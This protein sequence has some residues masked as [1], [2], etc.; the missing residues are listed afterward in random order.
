LTP[1]QKNKHLRRLWCSEISGPEKHTIFAGKAQTTI[2]ATPNRS[3]ISTRINISL[4]RSIYFKCN[5]AIESLPVAWCQIRQLGLVSGYR[6]SAAHILPT[7]FAQ[8]VFELHLV[9]F[10]WPG[11]PGQRWTVACGGWSDRGIQKSQSEYITA[12][13][14]V[15]GDQI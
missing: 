10:A 14:E 5:N 11:R 15:L 9:R 13:I 7:R 8:R 2:G 1:I 6:D 3:R 12:V 4:L